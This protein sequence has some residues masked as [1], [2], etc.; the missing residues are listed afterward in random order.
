MKPGRREH[1]C[2]TGPGRGDAPRSCVQGEGLCPGVWQCLSFPICTLQGWL[3][4]ARQGPFY[5]SQDA[6]ALALGCQLWPC[7]EPLWALGD[8]LGLRPDQKC[9]EGAAVTQQMPQHRSGRGRRQQPV[10]G[11]RQSHA[12]MGP[13]SWHR[14]ANFLAQA[15][16]ATQ[17]ARGGAARGGDQRPNQAPG[18]HG[19][20]NALPSRESG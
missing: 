3:W 16:E 13:A 12:A 18:G 19:L 2:N 1:P 17:E 14:G 6:A 20:Q 11:S 8:L 5:R 9:P 15:I 4:G 10:T 7:Q